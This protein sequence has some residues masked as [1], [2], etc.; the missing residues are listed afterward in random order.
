MINSCPA[1]YTK[2]CIKPK[3]ENEDLIVLWDIPEYSGHNEGED[4]ILRPDGK[5]ILKAQKVIFVIEMSVPWVENRGAKY[6]EKEEKYI[7]IVQNLKVDNPGYKVSQLTFI[8]DC[9]GGFSKTLTNSLKE[10]KF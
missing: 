7:D 4:R 10:L 2:L 1:W 3:Y 9:L 5:I 6:T 8:M